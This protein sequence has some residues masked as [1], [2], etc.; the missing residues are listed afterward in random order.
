LPLVLAD[1]PRAFRGL[2]WVRRLGV[3]KHW[4]RT[5]GSHIALCTVASTHQIPVLHKY[6]EQHLEQC[7][8]PIF[9]L[10]ARTCVTLLNVC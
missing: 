5:S 8:I 7:S 6:I 4:L 9:C 10:I 1:S 2:K 3:E